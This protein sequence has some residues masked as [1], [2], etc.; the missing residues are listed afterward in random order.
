[1]KYNGQY[2][3][4][5]GLR[6]SKVMNT[7]P[8]YTGHFYTYLRRGMSEKLSKQKKHKSLYYEKAQKTLF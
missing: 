3:F 7:Y 5:R 8:H 1:M 2:I 4:N 6:E